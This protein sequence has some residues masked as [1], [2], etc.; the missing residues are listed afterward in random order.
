[1]EKGNKTRTK[2]L[3][4]H[5]REFSAWTKHGESYNEHCLRKYILSFRLTR[6]QVVL[7]ICL[8]KS[9]LAAKTCNITLST[10]EP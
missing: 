10:F 6:E 9:R 5:L 7:F 2:V 4:K 8:V 3:G 1:M